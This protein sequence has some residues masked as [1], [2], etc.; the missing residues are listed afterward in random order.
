MSERGGIVGRGILLDFVRYAARTGIEYSANNYYAI[1]LAQIEEM[2]HDANLTLRQGDILIIRTGLSRWIR[3]STP[4]TAEWG[5]GG[6]I[7]VDPTPELLAW[8]WNH[9]LGAVASDA[10]AFE[11]IDVA[12]MTGKIIIFVRIHLFE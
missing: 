3:N 6:V 10:I 8:I 5:T 4:E 2:I 12:N 9:N 1:S 11:A 7:G